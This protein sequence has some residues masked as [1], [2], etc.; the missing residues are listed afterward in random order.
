MVL[1]ILN[2]LEDYHYRRKFADEKFVL[3]VCAIL[4][5]YHELD[6]YIKDIV[7]LHG[8]NEKGSRYSF[9][10]NVLFINMDKICPIGFK[11]LLQDNYYGM[12]NLMAVKIITHEFEH[13]LQERIK[14]SDDNT[15]E[16]KILLLGDPTTFIDVNS[17]DFTNKIKWLKYYQF[18]NRHYD[19]A[20]NERLAIIKSSLKLN[21]L[22][23]RS[24]IIFSPYYLLF[25]SDNIHEIDYILRHGYKLANEKT[26]S[27]TLWYLN[28][29]TRKNKDIIKNDLSLIDFS[30]PSEDRLLYGLP[31]TIDEYKNI[32]DVKKVLI[33]KYGGKNE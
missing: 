22:C 24:F 8:K 17:Y 4:T 5:K 29:L 2:I 13:A 26:T 11:K 32:D 30:I 15:I 28:K 25:M 27:P 7:I 33:K 9:T 3:K 21:N 14:D 1:D 16:R 20:P 6:K 18:Y 10:H 23:Q 12:Y 31:L 19:I